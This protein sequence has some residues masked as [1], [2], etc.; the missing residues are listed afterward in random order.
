VTEIDHQLEELFHRLRSVSGDKRAEELDRLKAADP[1]LRDALERLLCADAN[2]DARLDLPALEHV[3]QELRPPHSERFSRHSELELRRA[4]TLGAQ[5]QRYRNRE[6]LG[7]GGMGVVYR[8][9]DAALDRELAMKLIGPG[10]QSGGEDAGASAGVV[11]RF[12]REMHV[13]ARL[14]HPGIIPIHDVGVAED[15][16][17]FFTMK[18]VAPDADSDGPTG[19]SRTFESVLERSA[20]GDPNWG[21]G[22]LLNVLLRVCE[23]LDYAHRQGVVHRD[24]KPSNVMVGQFGEVY[25]TDW[26][27][28]QLD[29]D[30]WAPSESAQV[31]A[32]KDAADAQADE[33][34]EITL[35]GELLGTPEYMSPEQARGERVDHRSDVYSIGAILY[36]MLARTPPYQ[37]GTSPD[38]RR[39]SLEVL[40]I[41]R[42]EAP[43]P[44]RQLVPDAH[45]ELVAICDRAMARERGARYQEVSALAQDLRAFVEGRVVQA[46]AT[47]P[48]IEARKWIKRN[49]AL[50]STLLALLTLVL[51]SLAGVAVIQSAHRSK[52]QLV[53]DYSL[54]D[55]LLAE[56]ARLWPAAPHVAAGMTAWL[57]DAE[58]LLRRGPQHRAMTQ[59]DADG[60]IDGAQSA[61]R[62]LV[63]EF[64]DALESPVDSP[65]TAMRR[66]LEFANTIMARSVSGDDAKRRWASAVDEIE[67]SPHY[68]GLRL[69][70]QMGLLPIGPDKQSGLWEF[71][72][73][74]TGE[75]AVRGEDG[76]L[77]RS[78]S[79]GLV[80][81]LVPA[82]RFIMG[83][84][85]TPDLESTNYDPFARP[86]ESGG[87]SIELDAFFASKYEMTQAQWM[88]V[89][90]R[91]PSKR[92]PGYYPSG[93]EGNLLHPVE[94]I[95]WNESM[96]VLGRM[97]LTLP[98]EAQWEY[99]ARAGARTPWWTETLAGSTNLADI[100]AKDAGA[101]W[102]PEG[103][104]PSI[105]DGAV[106]H[107][108]VG[109]YSANAF[110]FHDV[111]GNVNEWCLDW[112]GGYH[113]SAR[114]RDG[115]REPTLR[116]GRVWRGGSYASTVIECRSAHRQ[117]DDPAQ[118]AQDRGVRPV[119]AVD[120][121][122][123]SVR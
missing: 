21:Q 78:E 37:D 118:G 35:A 115:L 114:A 3:L 45:D 52:L 49:P 120:E 86:V 11:L 83:A 90:G 24:L 41:L 109:S 96:L 39:A 66:R 97:G 85:A 34:T 7:R 101:P 123:S 92:R 102:L 28:A 55:Y 80:F 40:E 82:G 105:E 36:R 77:V 8:V 104:W 59:A 32:S 103:E 15:G 53:A 29:K 113:A 31:S 1:S 89:Q 116:D 33:P 76:R 75:A 60:G 61:K 43:R 22:R 62:R 9:H 44:V 46:F 73:L 63:I 88:R 18:L 2:S 72:H 74:E 119:R 91:N 106:F 108:E 19:R 30:M 51:A 112:F 81:V 48:W 50:A 42:S 4:A 79:T 122:S 93:L 68:G 121:L 98:T 71:A 111:A 23:A 64:M 5:V 10:W 13:L 56:E 67:K 117:R 65:L 6:E 99:L 70:P 20:E 84:D 14:D 100:S 25:V 16:R 12:F 69:Q 27:I 110:G 58:G 57:E 17:P 54:P 95:S 94:N 38:T 47:G 26:G 87:G 107:T